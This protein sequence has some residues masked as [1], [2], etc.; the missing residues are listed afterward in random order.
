MLISPSFFAS[1]ACVNRLTPVTLPPG[2]LRLTTRPD[3]T[4]SL[5][6]VNT[7]GI[8]VVAA[9]VASATERNNNRHPTMNKIGCQRR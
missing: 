3:L 1:T 5:P 6:L 8:V 7:I 2:R 9:F 4:T